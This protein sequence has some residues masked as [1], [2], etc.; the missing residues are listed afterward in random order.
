MESLI[1][2][3]GAT[4]VAH[5][6]VCQPAGQLPLHSGQQYRPAGDRVQPGEGGCWATH[7]LPGPWHRP[8]AGEQGGHPLDPGGGQGNRRVAP[9][10]P[11][12]RRDRRT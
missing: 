7:P 2:S 4:G 8:P 9:G 1:G 5:R 6:P 3:S 10:D 11:I 12:H